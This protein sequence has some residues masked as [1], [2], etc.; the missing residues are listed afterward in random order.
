MRW[1]WSG[2]VSA[3]VVVV[4][5]VVVVVVE[6]VPLQMGRSPFFP[7]SAAIVLLL[8]GSMTSGSFHLM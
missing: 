1:P 3:G 4:V 8:T 2:M 7:S 6:A 5:E